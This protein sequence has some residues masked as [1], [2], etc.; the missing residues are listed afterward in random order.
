M[1]KELQEL[2]AKIDKILEMQELILS[3]LSQ[4]TILTN[5]P[6]IQILKLSKKEVS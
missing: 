5:Q 6:N 1:N 4:N 3:K 2:S